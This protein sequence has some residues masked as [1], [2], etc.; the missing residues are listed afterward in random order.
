MWPLFTLMV[1][2]LQT[3]SWF[4][5]G[6][7][8]KALSKKTSWPLKMGPIGCPETSVRTTV[9]CIKS[10]ESADLIYVAVEAWNHPQMRN[11]NGPVPESPCCCDLPVSRLE[12]PF[13]SIWPRPKVS[14]I[15]CI[16]GHM[17]QYVLSRRRLIPS[18]TIWIS[19]DDQD[20]GP[21]C[22]QSGGKN[23]A[24]V[25]TCTN[26]CHWATK[27]QQWHMHED[28]SPRDVRAELLIRV[29]GRG[30]SRIDLGIDCI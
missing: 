8:A 14:A 9:C 27:W 1:A 6:L 5:E 7:R 24:T 25:W 13:L 2:T 22:G 30:L 23:M 3:N 28:W 17:M 26:G 4:F 10:Q 21:I 20:G 12:F 19:Y 15:I 29:M 11:R 16:V 18:Q